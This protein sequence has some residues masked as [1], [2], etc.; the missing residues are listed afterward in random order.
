MRPTSPADGRGACRPPA[1][2]LHSRTFHLAPVRTSGQAWQDSL[3]AV[4]R[5]QL[6]TSHHCSGEPPRRVRGCRPGVGGPR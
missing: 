4:A 5:G 2:G 6:G 3:L 1:P